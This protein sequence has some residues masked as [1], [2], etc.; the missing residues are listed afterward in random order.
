MN[1]TPH[2]SWVWALNKNKFMD[3]KHYYFILIR[4]FT[5][6][7]LSF[8]IRMQKKS[9]KFILKCYNKKENDLVPL[10]YPK[11]KWSKDLKNYT[12]SAICVSIFTER[13]SMYFDWKWNSTSN[14]INSQERRFIAV[15]WQSERNIFTLRK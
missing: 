7:L 9:F 4:Y 5:V 11:L 10:K 8:E 12:L 14:K 2:F 13:N 3:L 15:E 6:V 1:F